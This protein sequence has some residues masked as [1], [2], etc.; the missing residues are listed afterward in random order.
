M[1]NCKAK[2]KVS[3]YTS[4][5]DYKVDIYLR[6]VKVGASYVNGEPVEYQPRD[7]SLETLMHLYRGAS[8]VRPSR[9]SEK[10]LE[11]DIEPVSSDEMLLYTKPFESWTNTVGE[12]STPSPILHILENGMKT[13]IGS[14]SNSVEIFRLLEGV[15][16]KYHRT[17]LDRDQLVKKNLK[18]SKDLQKA[19]VLHSSKIQENEQLVQKSQTESVRW[20]ELA[21]AVQTANSELVE[22]MENMGEQLEFLAPQNLA[23]VKQQTNGLVKEVANCEISIK[24]EMEQR[25]MFEKARK[26]LAVKLIQE[27][28]LSKANAQAQEVEFRNVSKKLEQE[29][30]SLEQQIESARMELENIQ[31]QTDVIKNEGHLLKWISRQRKIKDEQLPVGHGSEHLKSKEEAKLVLSNIIDQVRKHR[32]YFSKLLELCKSVMTERDK[33]VEEAAQLKIRLREEFGNEDMVRMDDRQLR[34][35]CSEDE[36]SVTEREKKILIRRGSSYQNLTAK[37]GV[38]EMESR[39]KSKMIRVL[40]Q[41][42]VDEYAG[43]VRH[44]RQGTN[45]NRSLEKLDYTRYQ[46]YGDDSR[47]NVDSESIDSA[48]LGDDEAKSLIDRQGSFGIHKGGAGYDY[49]TNRSTNC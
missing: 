2:P 30:I 34:L 47:E 15:R 4:D 10:G 40:E 42:Q 31:R 23:V 43:V 35:E 21:T 39:H 7:G 22:N 5:V 25:I 20:K 18:L 3:T 36:S 24:R 8:S 26:E 28:A 29:N 16:E 38:L 33:T 27:K 12:I 9:K 37:I 46:I 48:E 1:G 17:K 45:V 41:E 44:H 13:A 6:G 11:M 32:N 49:R 14:C 19:Q